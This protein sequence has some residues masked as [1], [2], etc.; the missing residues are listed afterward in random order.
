MCVGGADPWTSLAFS[1]EHTDLE[2][3]VTDQNT[4]LSSSLLRFSPLSACAYGF[5]NGQGL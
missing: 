1:F 5:R 2:D 3:Q 4:R